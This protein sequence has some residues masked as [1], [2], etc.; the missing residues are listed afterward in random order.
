[1]NR[2]EISK[3]GNVFY[4]IDEKNKVVIAELRVCP[5][6]PQ[7]IFDNTLCK[8]FPKNNEWPVNH[9][10]DGVEKY[11]TKS[12]YIGKAICSP[13]DEFDIE[14]GKRLALARAKR[15]YSDALQRKFF[16]IICWLDSVNYKIG[17][18]Y[19]KLY[20]RWIDADRK[21]DDILIEKENG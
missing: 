13:N 7:D 14:Y 8:K 6:N 19:D 17:K 15:N 5:T 11:M 21:V 20:R 9:R 1:M 2:K 18:E 4:T 3:S 10:Y 12:S 16:N